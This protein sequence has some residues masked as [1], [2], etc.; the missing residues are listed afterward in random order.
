LF[1]IKFDDSVIRALCDALFKI[2]L[3]DRR[4]RAE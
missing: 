3:R 4:Q 2:K 1:K